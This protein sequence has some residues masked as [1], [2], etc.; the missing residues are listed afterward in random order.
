MKRLISTLTC[1]MGVTLIGCV[2]LAQPA[3]RIEWYRLEYSAPQLSLAPL[4][5]VLRIGTVAVAAAD[6]REPLVYRKDQ[7]SG[8]VYHYHRWAT[9]PG[10]L[11]HDVLVRDLAA[12]N[13]YRAVQASMGLVPADYDVSVYVETLEEQPQAAGC[14]AVLAARV[15]V[16]RQQTPKPASY[17]AEF[18]YRFEQ[19]VACNAPR[20]LV[21]ALSQDLQH[22]SE[23]LQRDLHRA[24]EQP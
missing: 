9:A 17:T 4:P 24:L 23:A 8:D 20:E 14:S 3:P 16:V 13:S 5:V 18:P 10:S 15:T 11:I 12:S 6:D 22:L 7:F 2:Q 21:A 19:P 1:L